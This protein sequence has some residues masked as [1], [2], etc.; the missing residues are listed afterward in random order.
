M[1]CLLLDI[2]T[3]RLK[4]HSGP[5]TFNWAQN[6]WS[7]DCNRMGVFGDTSEGD[8]CV[9]GHR[10]LIVDY[11]LEDEDDYYVESFDELN[12]DY[13]PKT[14]EAAYRQYSVFRENVQE[15]GAG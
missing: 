4:W 1:K 15:V 12:R 8:Y 9:G 11:H 5:D 13:P 7:C 6:N 3:N 14:R 2:Q 10:Y